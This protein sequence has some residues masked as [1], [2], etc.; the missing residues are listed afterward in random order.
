M[1]TLREHELLN[2]RKCLRAGFGEV[3][4]V[5]ALPRHLVSLERFIGQSLG[6]GEICKVRF[7]LADDLAGLFA[8]VVPAPQVEKVVRGYRVRSKISA[9]DGVREAM[10]AL[11]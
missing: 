2:V 9:S 3:V 6:E 1:T 5:A 10:S 4:V 7:V 11:F 8:D